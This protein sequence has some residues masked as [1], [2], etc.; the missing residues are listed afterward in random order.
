MKRL[1]CLLLLLLP[2]TG[3][4]FLDDCVAFSDREW[5]KFADDPISPCGAPPGPV[6]ACGEDSGIIQTGAR[7]PAQTVEP[8]R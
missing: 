8:P 4:A 3:C 5:H 2:L 7:L 6:R 1:F